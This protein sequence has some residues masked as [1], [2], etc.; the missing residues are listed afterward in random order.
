MKL[1][2]PLKALV[3]GLLVLSPALGH[4]QTT[5]TTD[6]SKSDPIQMEA[7]SVTE[8]KAFSDQAIPGKTPVAF[9]ELGKQTI[10]EELGSRDIPLV[11]N[12][13]PSVFST[14]DSGGAGDA[15]VN[16]RGFNQRNVSI[17][18]NGVP[19]NDIE[20]GWLYWSNWDGLGDVSTAIQLQRGLSNVVLPTPSIGGTMNIIS[21]PAEA[22]RGFSLKAEVGSDDF[23]KFTGVYS[24]G[25]IDDRVAITVG[26]V[27]KEGEGYVQGTWTKGYGYYLAALWKMSPRNRFEFFWIGAPQRHG[28][29]TFASNIAAYDTGYARSLGYSEAEIAA[30]LAVGPVNAGQDFNPNYAPVS[31]SYAGQQYYWEEL[32]PREKAGFLNE[33]ENYFHKPQANLN[34]YANLSSQLKVTTVFYYSGGRGGGAGTL[35][36][37][38]SSDAFGRYPNSDP[39]WGSNINWDATIASNAGSRN[40]RGGAKTPGRSLGILRNSVNNQDQFGIVSKAV[41]KLSDVLT[42][43]GGFDWRTAEIHHFREVRDLLGGEY[44]LPTTAQVSEFL[45][46]GASTQLRLGDKVDYNNTNTVDWLGTF[47]LAQY[48]QGPVTAFGVYGYS[49]IDY[50]YV[51]HFRRAAPGSNQAMS[52][53]SGWIDGHQIKGGLRYAFNDGFSAFVNAGWVS[54]V[55]IFDGAINDIVG[56]KV[57]TENETFKSAEAGFRYVTRDQ[58]F[59]VNANYYYTEWRERTVSL[60]NE[61]ADTIT[62]LRGINSNYAGVELESAW[63][64]NTWIRFDAAASIGNWYYLSDVPAETYRISSGDQVPTS[65]VLYI[66]SLKV[67]DAPQTQ[68][69]YAVTAFPTKGLSVKLQGRSYARYWSDYLPDSRQSASDRGQPWRIPNYSVFD[70]HVNYRLP[71]GDRSNVSLFAHVFNLFDETYV[72]DATDNSSFEAIRTAPSHSAQRAEVFLAPPLK[73]NLGARILF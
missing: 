41:Y 40:A 63:Q 25:L 50:S 22:R 35:N 66:S 72:S 46:T 44:Y 60:V 71:L 73:F 61:Q 9:T 51:D 39:R 4:A 56:Q 10:A 29:R 47:A 16:V 55:P 65:A 28:Q 18:I 69:A 58:K 32:H 45:S 14:T 6:P 43:T 13:G 12:A 38:S 21:D 67:G 23:Y 11:L 15:R 5:A 27:A 1:P 8:L 20:N 26:G 33:R 53:D 54:K 17:L 49:V 3:G 64:P 2:A 31:P 24:T 57:E 42:L 59:N 36:N 30:A 37:G 19:T 68:Y 34:W 70:L 62:Y 7:F 52:L 48:E